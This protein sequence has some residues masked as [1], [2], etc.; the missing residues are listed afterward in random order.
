[1]DGWKTTLVGA[2]MAVA[3]AGCAGASDEPGV[4]GVSGIS[5]AARDRVQTDA[6]CPA[7]DFDGFLRAFASDEN[8]RI[9]HTVPVVSV[10]DYRDPDAVDGSEIIKTSVP[11]DRY[12]GFTLAFRDGAFHHMD[13]VGE[14]DPAPL[15]PKI[16]A[17]K[18]GYFVSYAYGMSEG[19]SWRFEGKDG[20]WVL[21]EDPEPPLE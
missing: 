21:A 4:R 18:D 10:A 5:A 2:A 7:K 15:T 19:N 9:T 11:R 1:M 12:R 20:C 6:S 8:V 3:I 14:M 13:S 16:D 17:R